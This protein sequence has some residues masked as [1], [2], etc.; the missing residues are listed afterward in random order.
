MKKKVLKI[1][2]LIDAIICMLFLLLAI[3]ENGIAKTGLGALESVGKWCLYVGIVIISSI[4]LLILVYLL[5][6][7]EKKKEKFLPK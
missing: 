7:E 1:L 2:C 4:I 3:Y 5:I 6:Q